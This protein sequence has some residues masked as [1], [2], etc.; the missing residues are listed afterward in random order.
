MM[1]V[2]RVY[3]FGQSFTEMTAKIVRIPVRVVVG[4]LGLLLVHKELLPLARVPASAFP[5]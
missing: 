2:L 5:D 4:V 1:V 3:G